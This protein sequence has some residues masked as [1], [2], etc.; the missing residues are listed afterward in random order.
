MDHVP[1]I[2]DLVV[3]A[4]GMRPSTRQGDQM[5]TADE[6]V[7]AI[8]VEPHPQTMT[9]QARGHRVEYL[10]QGEAAGGG[11]LH[12]NLLVIRSA[13]VRQVRER[14]AFAVDALG[15]ASIATTDDLVDEAA[16]SD[17]VI[18]IGAGRAGEAHRRSPA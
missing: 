14:G 5:R 7:E 18:E 1:I 15:V 16:I 10:A 2:D 9:N 6:Q 8:V 13:A 11:D 4:A 12:D 17:E 3:L